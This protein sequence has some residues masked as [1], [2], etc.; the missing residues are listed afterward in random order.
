MSDKIALVRQ[1]LKGVRQCFKIVD[2]LIKSGEVMY[3][4]LEAA[5]QIRTAIE[6]RLRAIKGARRKLKKTK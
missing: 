5:E 2:D 3:N 6:Q 1:Q 4:G